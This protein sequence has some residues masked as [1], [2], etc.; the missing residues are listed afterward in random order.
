M[1]II[2]VLLIIALFY[3]AYAQQDTQKEIRVSIHDFLPAVFVD[4]KGE[5]QGFSPDLLSLM[6][7]IENWKINYVLD[8][9]KD[10]L[11]LLKNGE[12]DLK[13]SIAYSA[14]REQILDYKTFL[15]C[16]DNK[17]TTWYP[18]LAS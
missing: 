6:V 7:Q 2:A 18:L 12:V 16:L 1:R 11:I 4:K 17:A 10:G 3:P 14:E 13:A 15:F 5:V 8:E 9:W